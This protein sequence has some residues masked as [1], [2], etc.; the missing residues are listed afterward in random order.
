MK[1]V[2]SHTEISGDSNLK[3][4]LN[5][6]I[7]CVWVFCLHVYV[8][9]VSIAPESAG[10]RVTDGCKPPRG[11]W[12]LNSDPL[13]GQPLLLSAEPSQIWSDLKVRTRLYVPEKCFSEVTKNVKR[14]RC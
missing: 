9:H 2:H 3:S 12:K 8:H 6:F 11:C 4:I 13:E 5:I 7:L 10:T 14:L 1:S